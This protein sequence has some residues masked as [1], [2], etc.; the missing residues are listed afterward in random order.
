MQRE[1]A[2]QRPLL[3]RL[4]PGSLLVRGI[5]SMLIEIDREH[6]TRVGPVC[7]KRHQP[8]E[9]IPPEGLVLAA[10]VV[11][12]RGGVGVG[13]LIGGAVGLGRR[14]A[15]TVRCEFEQRGAQR[16]VVEPGSSV[17]LRV[18]FRVVVDQRRSGCWMLGRKPPQPRGESQ[19]ADAVDAVVV[20]DRV[21]QLLR[22][23][24]LRIVSL[25]ARPQ[26]A[27]VDVHRHRV[28]AA[29]KFCIRARLGPVNL[30]DRLD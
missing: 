13:A 12:R 21:E 30:L 14:G 25:A 15:V 1:R 10:V 19:G 8:V 4:A 2:A 22:L 29:G 26:L 17:I 16:R 9:V 5:R 28:V 20:G 6:V 18:V 3:A 24:G 7:G 27:R 11:D 23:G